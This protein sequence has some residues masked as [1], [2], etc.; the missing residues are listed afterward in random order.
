MRQTNIIWVLFVACTGVI[1][2]TLAVQ[3]HKEHSDASD[4]SN[5]KDDPIASNKAV[6]MGS[7][8]KRRRSGNTV[9][10]INQSIARNSRSSPQTSGYLPPDQFFFFFARSVAL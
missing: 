2:C 10:S 6:F 7:N 4:V 1:D 5:Q 9:G 8:L 3:K